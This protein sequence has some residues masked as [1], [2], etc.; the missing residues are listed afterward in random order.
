MGFLVLLEGWLSTRGRRG[1]ESGMRVEKGP[2]V[3]GQAGGE[4]MDVCVGRPARRP[5]L[6]EHATDEGDDG[7]L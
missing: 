4:V 1:S 5:K 2:G 6:S 7:F 3:A